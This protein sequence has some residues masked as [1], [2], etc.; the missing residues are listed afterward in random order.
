M[1]KSIRGL[2]AAPLALMIGLL[3]TVVQAQTLYKYTDKDGKVTFS[4]RVPKAGE[5]AEAVGTDKADKIGNTVKLETKDGK[6]VQQ[7]FSNVKARGDARIAAR[8]KLQ[9][10]VDAAEERL[11]K[12]RKAL[13]AGRDP[14]EGEQRVVVR[15]GGNSVLRTEEY[16]ARIAGLEASI[17][18]AEQALAASQDKYN[19]SAP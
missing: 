3:A 17:K 11:T 1:H 14:K 15:K 7:Q 8:E 19:R 10:D 4:D 13:D 5:K 18:K 12:A 2:L 9:K 16:H 6:G